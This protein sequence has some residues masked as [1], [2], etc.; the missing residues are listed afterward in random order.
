MK[1]GKLTILANFQGRAESS[2]RERR[3]WREA[4]YLR[5]RQQE[6][7]ERIR[8][9]ESFNVGKSKHAMDFRAPIQRLPNVGYLA[10]ILPLKSAKPPGNRF[11]AC[12]FI[13]CIEL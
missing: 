11:S 3:S 4:R 7:T 13:S 8:T 10:I 5:K 1:L 9:C 12:S 6:I 2:V